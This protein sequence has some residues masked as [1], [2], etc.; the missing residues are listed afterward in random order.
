MAIEQ[1][2]LESTKFQRRTKYNR[3]RRHEHWHGPNCRGHSRPLV[4]G[5]ASRREISSTQ[6]TLHCVLCLSPLSPCR[7]RVDFESLAHK[8]LHLGSPRVDLTWLALSLGPFAVVDI[9]SRRPNISAAAEPWIEDCELPSVTSV[10]ALWLPA[11]PPCV[12]AH[13]RM[14]CVACTTTPGLIGLQHLCCRVSLGVHTIVCVCV[15]PRH[16]G[17]PPVVCTCVLLVGCACAHSWALDFIWGKVCSRDAAV[18]PSVRQVWGG[19]ASRQLC[20]NCATIVAA[21]SNPKFADWGGHNL[22]PLLGRHKCVP[23]GMNRRRCMHDS[24]N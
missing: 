4:G 13:M 2:E 5:R 15:F 16:T 6:S 12:C 18:A 10:A 19:C 1:M 11:W 8:V 22:A 21:Q 14:G 20:D 7:W 9:P 3:T 23:P 24:F 17:A